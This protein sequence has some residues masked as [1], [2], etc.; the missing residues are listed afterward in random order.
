[1]FVVIT[2]GWFTG[3][4]WLLCCWLCDCIA[5]INSVVVVHCLFIRCGLI[6]W[7]CYS[8][9]CCLQLFDWCLLVL[10]LIDCVDLMHYG[11]CLS[12]WADA[13]VVYGCVVL[14]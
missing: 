4:G 8:C 14:L 5:L 13:V 1:M 6:S 9:L 7:C 2:V 11:V 10:R 3:L 12:L